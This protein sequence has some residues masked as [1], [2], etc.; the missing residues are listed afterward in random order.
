MISS[1]RESERGRRTG[2]RQTQ[3]APTERVSRSGSRKDRWL[4][5]KEKNPTVHRTEIPNP[6]GARE[7]DG[8]KCLTVLG[9]SVG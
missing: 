8:S 4:E 9:E 7:V 2:W 3:D 6:E 1:S 5:G